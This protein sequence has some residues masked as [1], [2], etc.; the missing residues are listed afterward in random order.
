LL[1][2][3]IILI[4]YFTVAKLW[5]NSVFLAFYSVI[6]LDQCVLDIIYVY[7]KNRVF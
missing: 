5:I 6:F 2:I 1:I 3:I 4:E 7:L